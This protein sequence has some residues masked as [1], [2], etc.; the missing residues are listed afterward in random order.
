MF[1]LIG[2]LTFLTTIETLRICRTLSIFKVSY[3]NIY[4]KD[5]MIPR[6]IA[7]GFVMKFKPFA[8]P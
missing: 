7:S 2:L 8:V 6:E 3:I 5:F 1:I 4:A